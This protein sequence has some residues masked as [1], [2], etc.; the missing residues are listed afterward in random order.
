[1]F[2]IGVVFVFLHSIP[3][4]QQGLTVISQEVKLVGPATVAMGRKAKITCTTNGM[5]PDTDSTDSAPTL[6]WKIGDKVEDG[7]WDQESQYFAT[8]EVGRNVL[9]NYD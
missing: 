8:K 3:D 7:V 5:L 1:M 9:C 6:K 2:G 4:T